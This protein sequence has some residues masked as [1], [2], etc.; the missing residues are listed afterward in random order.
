MPPTPPLRDASAGE[1]ITRALRDLN[2]VLR[3][4]VELAKF[5]LVE[6]S[7][8]AAARL[9][10]LVIGAVV[11]L[12]AVG[13]LSATIVVAL[14]FLIDP[15]WIRLLIMTAV[16][17]ALSGVLVHRGVLKLRETELAPVQAIE[18]AEQ[19]VAALQSV[20]ETDEHA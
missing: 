3:A 5:E 18:E 15:L 10:L 14:G 16:L 11:G 20:K 19:T 13:M 4:E 17:S 12:F 8:K 2:T 6:A 7:K 9:A 1:L